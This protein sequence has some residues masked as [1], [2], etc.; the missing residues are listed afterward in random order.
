MASSV[1]L[2]NGKIKKI[3]FAKE[4]TKMAKDGLFRT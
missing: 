2:E 4:R 3:N 1:N